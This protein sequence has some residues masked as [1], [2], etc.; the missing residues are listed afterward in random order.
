MNNHFHDFHKPSGRRGGSILRGGNPSEDTAVNCRFENKNI[1]VERNVIENMPHA[2]VNF[3][4][5]KD[6]HT[7]RNV[8]RGSGSVAIRYKRGAT[9]RVSRNILSD[10]NVNYDPASL[11]RGGATSSESR[12]V[13][14]HNFEASEREAIFRNVNPDLGKVDY[15]TLSYDDG[16][17]FVPPVI[18]ACRVGL[19]REEVVCEVDV[20]FAPVQCGEA[21]KFTVIDGDRILAVAECHV[22]EHEPSL[23]SI[24]SDSLSRNPSLHLRLSSSTLTTVH[25]RIAPGSA[26]VKATEAA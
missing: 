24:K 10:N 25:S 8:I 19:S 17:I 15:N 5:A 4:R 21:A 6:A 23:R 14:A 20:M 9:G 22:E 13:V 7:I 3:E 1:T 16:G 11:R 26:D 12:G 2:E 18:Q